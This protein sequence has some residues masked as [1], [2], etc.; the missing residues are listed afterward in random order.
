MWRGRGRGEV[1][2]ALDFEER[3]ARGGMQERWEW[4][5]GGRLC[6]R[7]GWMERDGRHWGCGEKMQGDLRCG[8][9]LD[10]GFEA[11]AKVG[12]WTELVLVTGVVWC[13]GRRA[14]LWS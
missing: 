3:K 4:V 9:A 5:F 1:D 11:G 7:A 13:G 6:G 2:C 14:K 12:E 10:R 8:L